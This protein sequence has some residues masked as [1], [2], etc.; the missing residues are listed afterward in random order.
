MN[1]LWRKPERKNNKGNLTNQSVTCLKKLGHASLR[2]ISKS[3]KHHLVRRLPNFVYK[4]DFLCDAC[5]K[6]KQ[7]CARFLAHEGDSSKVFSIFYKHVQNEKKVILEESLGIKIFK[8][9]TKK[10]IFSTTSQHQEHHNKIILF[11]ERIGH[12]RKWP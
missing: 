3:N 10:T 12:F 6:G 11:R 4:F 7:T 2:L 9:S 5:Q 8:S 1:H